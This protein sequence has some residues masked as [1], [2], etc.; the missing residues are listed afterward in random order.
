M[1][2]FSKLLFILWGAAA[3]FSLLTFFVCGYDVDDLM[4]AGL[5]GVLA[6]DNYV[7]Y[8]RGV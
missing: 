4:T 6:F 8:K 7:D 3:A 1:K 2:N 5:E